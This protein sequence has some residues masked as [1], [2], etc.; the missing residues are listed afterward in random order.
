MKMGQDWNMTSTVFKFPLLEISL[1]KTEGDAE[2]LSLGIF[3]AVNRYLDSKALIHLQS[4][5][6]HRKFGER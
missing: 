6:R 1:R 3:N 5:P 4:T 2:R